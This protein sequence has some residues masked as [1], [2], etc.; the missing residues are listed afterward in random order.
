MVLGE[1]IGTTITA[2][3]AAK[4]TNVSAKRSARVHLIFNVIGVLWVLLVFPPF[5]KLINGFII[6]AG[7]IS[8]YESTEVI[9]IALSIFHSSFNLINVILL[10][11]FSGLISKIVIKILPSKEEDEEFQNK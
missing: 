4:V 8:P 3:I 7:G 11:G 2:N 5:L 6:S 9:P 1:N 10:I